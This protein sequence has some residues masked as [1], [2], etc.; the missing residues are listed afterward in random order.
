MRELAES[1]RAERMS[2]VTPML[3]YI[4]GER[5][6]FMSE[7]VTLS[8]GTRKEQ[9]LEYTFRPVATLPHTYVLILAKIGN[10]QVGC[11]GSMKS[12]WKA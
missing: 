3:G 12:I 9:Y 6:T 10:D 2:L 1:R 5:I 7:S 8:I 11:S 4:A